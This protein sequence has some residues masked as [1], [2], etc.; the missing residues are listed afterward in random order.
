MEKIH[1]LKKRMPLILHEDD[2]KK[3]LDDSLNISEIKK[4][5]QPFDENEMKAFTI[6]RDVN[7]SRY[8]RNVEHIIHQVDYSELPN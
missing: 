4:L 6:S 8:D 7:N 3:W 1:N 5:I 2:E